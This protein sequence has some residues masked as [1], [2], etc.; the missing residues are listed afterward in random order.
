MDTIRMA[1]TKAA[2]TEAVPLTAQAQEMAARSSAR[3]RMAD[4]MTAPSA[5]DGEA[6]KMPTATR[7]ASGAPRVSGAASSS[8]PRMNTLIAA[9]PAAESGVG[10]HQRED[11][12]PRPAQASMAAMPVAKATVGASSTRMRRCRR[13]IWVAVKATPTAAT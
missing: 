2:A 1:A 9:N 6:A 5:N 13:A 12:L 4:G 10:R 7:T 8:P 3:A 11:R